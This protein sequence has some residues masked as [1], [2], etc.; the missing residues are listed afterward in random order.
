[1]PHRQ[2]NMLHVS[3]V[4]LIA[5]AGL[6]AGCEK[7]DQP[8]QSDK[9]IDNKDGTS[10]YT[11]VCT[12]GMVADLAREIAGDR[13]TVE[14]IIGASVDPHLYQ[15][16]RGDI[17]KLNEADV[18]FYNGLLLEG[19]MEDILEKCGGVAVAAKIDEA[20]LIAPP[21]TPGHFDPHVW[22]DVPLWQE[23]AREIAAHL[24]KYD[25]AHADE[26][27]A[28]LETL[29]PKLDRLH[30]YAQKCI[31]TIPKDSRVL[32][33]AHDAFEYF[34]RA[35]DIEVRG[36]Q[37]IST[38]SEA[39][40]RDIN[41]LVDLLVKRKIRAVFVES[42]VSEKNVRALVEGAAARQHELSI[43]GTLF[44]DAMG[45]PGTYEGTYTGMID[46]NVTTITRALGGDAPAGGMDGK[47]S[48]AKD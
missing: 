13:A 35:Y 44:S 7:G 17:V 32:V 24:S 23:A 21:D 10:R 18:V 46:H 47:L 37:G 33:T 4:A 28:N 25:A 8:N 40:V 16:S 26:Y 42:S 34:G 36:I 9:P 15:A 29:I 14:S 11:I 38:E 41:A 39:G 31:A 1:M 6:L 45:A 20:K 30:A 27:S 19:K 2:R 43:G 5:V 3:L 22:M 12:V 48:V